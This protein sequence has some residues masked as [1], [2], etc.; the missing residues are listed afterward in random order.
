MS[1]ECPSY[2]KSMLLQYGHSFRNE[3]PRSSIF[4]TSDLGRNNCP[5]PTEVSAEYQRQM[6]VFLWLM[7][8]FQIVT[9]F[10]FCTCN[11]T[12]QRLRQRWWQASKTALTIRPGAAGACQWWVEN[13]FHHIDMQSVREERLRKTEWEKTRIRLQTRAALAFGGK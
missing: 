5:S 1:T 10:I 6:A 11:G 8:A 12:H 7:T 4:L 3:R 2:A 9:A 13:L